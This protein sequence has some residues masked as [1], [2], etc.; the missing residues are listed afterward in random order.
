MIYSAAF[1]T[2]PGGDPVIASGEV[3]FYLLY[4]ESAGTEYVIIESSKPSAFY[5]YTYVVTDSGCN[6]QWQANH[7]WHGN[8]KHQM[9]RAMVI[10]NG[11]YL[12]PSAHYLTNGGIIRSDLPL[13]WC[14]DYSAAGNVIM[15]RF[16]NF[17]DV[18][19]WKKQTAMWDASTGTESYW[20]AIRPSCWISTISGGGMVLAPEQGG[21]C[22][23]NVWFNTS[24]GFVAK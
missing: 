16:E 14:G 9:K 6:Y 22:A 1:K 24:V 7:P 18:W 11:V 3:A 17:P 19:P 23:C 13:A 12:Y 10:G 2:A 5:L 4:A 21:G 20:D 15:G 8:V